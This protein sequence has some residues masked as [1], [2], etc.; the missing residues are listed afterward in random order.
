[1]ALVSPPQCSPPCS[2]LSSGCGDKYVFECFEFFGSGVETGDEFGVLEVLVVVLHDE[3]S[4]LFVEGTFG[5]GDDE[6]AFD[7][8]EDVVEGPLGGIPVLFQGIDAN[9]ALFRYVGMEDLGDEEAW[10]VPLVPLGGLFG[11][12]CSTASLQRKTPPS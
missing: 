2:S 8:L 3:F 9:L 1:M 6:E 5:E 11:K 7:D 10:V 12:S 4:G